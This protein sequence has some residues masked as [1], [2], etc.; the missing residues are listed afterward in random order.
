MPQPKNFEKFQLFGLA[1]Q[2]GFNL[3]VPLMLGVGGGVWLDKK[4]STS[5]LFVLIG[6]FGGMILAGFM[7]YKEIKPFLKNK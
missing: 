5:P 3:V 6:T 7:F 2:L 1:M 4:F